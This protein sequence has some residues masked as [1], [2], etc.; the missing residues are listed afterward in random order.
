VLTFAGSPD[1]ALSKTLDN[2][3]STLKSADHSNKTNLYLTCESLRYLDTCINYSRDGKCPSFV[4][5]LSI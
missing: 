4:V 2:I 1:F 5:L 3:S